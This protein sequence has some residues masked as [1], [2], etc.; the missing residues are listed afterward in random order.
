MLVDPQSVREF[1]VRLF[2]REDHAVLK[3]RREERHGYVRRLSSRHAILPV[4]DSRGCI[5]RIQHTAGA[6]CL[7]V[8]LLSPHLGSLDLADSPV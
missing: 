1:D 8:V 5:P 2:M 7:L 4:T 3:R 6:L